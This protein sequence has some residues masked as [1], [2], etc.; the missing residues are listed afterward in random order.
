M[1]NIPLDLSAKTYRITANAGNDITFAFEFLAINTTGY[2]FEFRIYD[3]AGVLIDTLTEGD[4]I[5]NTP[6]VNSIVTITIG[7]ALNPPSRQ[8]TELNT[9]FWRTDANNVRTFATGPLVL[10]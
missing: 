1:A 5:T 2:T 10:V 4:G 3:A 6:G 7:I 9:Q 8:G